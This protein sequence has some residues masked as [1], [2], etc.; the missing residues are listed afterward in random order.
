M[1]APKRRKR[2]YCGNRL[3]PDSGGDLLVLNIAFANP[4]AQH[5]FIGQDMFDKD[6]VLLSLMPDRPSCLMLTSQCSKK[7]RALR[8]LN[9]MRCTGL[10][11]DVVGSQDV[12]TKPRH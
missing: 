4:D 1:T 12:G 6:Q 5:C 11:I 10:Q 8:A 3:P 2:V 9:A 7:W